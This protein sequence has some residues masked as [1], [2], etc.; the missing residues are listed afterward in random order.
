MHG[1]ASE[2]ESLPQA[3]KAR[4][5]EFLLASGHVEEVIALCC[6]QEA[7]ASRRVHANEGRAVGANVRCRI[8]VHQGLHYECLQMWAYAR[9]LCNAGRRKVLQAHDHKRV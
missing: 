5:L 3:S 2:K 7:I 4:V 1:A 8:D 6:V 9:T